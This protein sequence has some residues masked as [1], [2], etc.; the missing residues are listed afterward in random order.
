MIY[1][2]YKYLTSVKVI[3][4][5]NIL[6]SYLEIICGNTSSINETIKESFG[7]KLNSRV[8]YT[9]IEGYEPVNQHESSM[10]MCQSNAKWSDTLFACQ[11]YYIYAM[12]T[13]LLD[14]GGTDKS[15]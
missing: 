2:I 3:I 4:S 1:D 9:C 10:I 7:N 8:S 14:I 12:K 11:S 13:R 6:H 5:I 15:C